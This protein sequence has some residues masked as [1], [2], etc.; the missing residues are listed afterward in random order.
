MSAG[1]NTC[2]LLAKVQLAADSIWADNATKKDYMG[3]VEVLTAI[4]ANQTVRF[5]ELEN[6]LKDKT[7]TIYWP[8][9]CDTETTT[10]TDD[11][12]PGGTKP[13]TSCQDYTLNVCREVDFSIDEKVYRA[14]A[15]T[16]E[17]ALAKSMLVKMKT[18][19]EYLAS[20]AVTALDAGKGVNAYAGGKG[21][22]A[23]FNTTIPAAYWN[24]SLFGYLSLVAKV[25]KFNSPYLIS[26]T[27]LYEAAFNAS[28]NSGNSDGKGAFN[29]FNTL[30]LYF[31]VFNIDSVQ[32][33]ATYL[34]NRN[35]LAFVSK[36]YNNW[37][38]T[39]EKVDRFGGPGSSTGAR[40]Q[41]ESKN[42]PGVFYD[43]IYKI[44]CAG[45]EITHNFKIQ[46]NGG[47]FRNP[48]GC[49]LNNTNIL[50]FLCA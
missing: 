28:A 29:L 22:V 42:L 25:N 12:T 40:Y 1:I 46:F 6:P 9:L 45:N 16:F 31:D 39:D 18:L 21:T 36:T 30:P 20:L 37:S 34:I 2:A 35:A 26:G 4:R 48:V 32:G 44:A 19:D 27:N 49:N 14:V 8:E 50:E 24:A 38:S 5:A 43:V 3:E 15:T 41:V 17:E 23:G 10:C 13:G 47:I 11:C 7:V 33:Q